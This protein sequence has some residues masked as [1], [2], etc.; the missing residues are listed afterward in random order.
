MGAGIIIN[1]DDFGQSVEL[2]NRIIELHKRGIVKSTSILANGEGFEHAVWLAKRN[3]GLSVGIHLNLSQ[4]S[5][6]TGKPKSL[7]TKNGQFAKKYLAVLKLILRLPNEK[8]IEEEFTAQIER[9]RNAGIR[10]SHID[11]HRHILVFPLV[12]R[13]VKKLAGKYGIRHIRIP[14]ET[15]LLIGSSSIINIINYLGILPFAF[16]LRKYMPTSFFFGILTMKNT[17]VQHIEKIVGKLQTAKLQTANKGKQG[18]ITAE[19]ACHLQSEKE[20]KTYKEFSL[21]NLEERGIRLIS[22]K[23]M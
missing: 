1:A 23:E 8:E 15:P 4:G 7:T 6:L 5:S 20:L 18:T 3:P 19:I 17:T 22:H 2:N 10:I 12:W 16:P 21:K 11:S 14:F 9:A 13:A